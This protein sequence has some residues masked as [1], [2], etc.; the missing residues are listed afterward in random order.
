MAYSL[1]EKNIYTNRG[2][3]RFL[4]ALKSVS[5]IVS[6]SSNPQIYVAYYDTYT[7]SNNMKQT[8]ITEHTVN[9]DSIFFVMNDGDTWTIDDKREFSKTMSTSQFLPKTFLT[10]NDFDKERSK[11]DAY[12]VW[13]VKSRGG[14]GGKAVHCKYT[15]DLTSN[16]GLQ[17][18]IQEEI[19]PIDL[20]LGRKYVIRY[21]ILL[22]KQRAWFHKKAFVVVH[23]KEYS[24]SSDDFDIQVNHAGYHRKD[25]NGVQLFPL[26]H[27]SQHQ[28]IQ[29]KHSLLLH[30]LFKSSVD[31]CAKYSQLVQ[32]ST[33]TQFMLL[34]VD[35][36]PMYEEDG[37]YNIRYVEV[38]RF[39]N[40][41]HT[42]IVNRDVNEKV[43]RDTL[44]F[45]MH[46]DDPVDNEYVQ[47]AGKPMVN[48]AP[49][50][51]R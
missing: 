7:Q 14:T 8:L 24:E 25:A 9:E 37:S 46:V 49:E 15:K 47:V 6:T 19:T 11:Y 23:G 31:L 38:N 10:Y 12:K 30:L 28:E 1:L 32:K 35:A 27:I 13:F 48:H 5:H 34:G 26:T 4:N 44:L 51:F 20:W 17:Y 42:H 41:C 43:L 50:D 36:I 21:Y 40:I 22:W 29:G 2:R 18:V 3:Q 16:P 45:F 33:D 39:P